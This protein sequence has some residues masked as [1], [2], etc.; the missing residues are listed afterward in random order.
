M[1]FQNAAKALNGLKCHFLF[2]FYSRHFFYGFLPTESDIK[3]H[4]LQ[5]SKKLYQEEKRSVKERSY[6]RCSN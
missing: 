1:T 6:K 4:A 2:I 5:M 3:L